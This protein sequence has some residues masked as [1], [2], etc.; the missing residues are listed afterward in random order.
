M[1]KPSKDIDVRHPVAE[2]V[3]DT[4]SEAV[5]GKT[6]KIELVLVSVLAGGHVLLEDVPGV[7][8]TLLV[9]ALASALGMPYKRVQFTPDLLPGDVLGVSVYDAREGR[10]RFQPGPI[11]THILMADEINRA[12]PK[13]Q[14]ALLEAMEERRV[15]IDGTTHPLPHPFFVLATQNPVEYEG[16]Y[17][18][19]E[20]Q[21]DRF[22]L[23]IS[24]GYPDPAD[25]EVLL[26]RYGRRDDVPLPEPR[27]DREGLLRLMAER[28]AV[29]VAPEVRKILLEIIRRT[30]QDRRLRL[31]AS[32]RATIAYF[33]AVQA[34]ALVRG[35]DYAVPDDVYALARAVLAHRVVI[36]PTA[37]FDGVSAEQVLDD[38]VGRG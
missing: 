13:T 30:R 16:T 32:P 27:L 33:R 36:D 31:G 26:E 7:G 35:R 22:L 10:F 37:A 25:E 1:R 12:T 15:T 2:T 20:A 23:K 8:K 34:R 29:Y 9:R 3:I 6:E 17:P 21:L 5:I 24:L 28:E 4:V 19:P 14:S 18:L 38:L 11:F